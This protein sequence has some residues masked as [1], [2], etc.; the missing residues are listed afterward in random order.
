MFALPF[1]VVGLNRMVLVP[2]FTVTVSV[3]VTQVFHAPVPSNDGVCTVDPLTIRLAGR[4]VVVPLANWTSSV[5][6]PAADAFTANC[7]YAPVAF[8]PLQNPLP[9]KG[10]QSESMV[11]VQVAFSAS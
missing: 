5:A 8:V 9:E 10:A 6:L 1:A 3:L 4:T 2:A 11:P 7:T